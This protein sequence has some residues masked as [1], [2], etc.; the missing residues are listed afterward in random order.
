MTSGF[1]T[2]SFGLPSAIF[3]PWSSTTIW[4]ATAMM[5]RITCSTMT[6]VR[7]RFESLPIERHRLVDLGRVKPGHH[8]V[9]QQEARLGRER[10]RHL[11]PPLV[12]RREIARRRVLLGGKSD[13]FDRL[14]R[15]R[16]RGVE[17]LVAQEGAGH[18][19]RQHRHRAERLRH[20]K[21]AR[22]AVRANI[23]RP[24][25]RRSRGRRPVIEPA[26]GR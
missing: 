6:M 1:A 2:I 16:A 12:D 3:C 14:A 11:Q 4:R 5:A 10:A 19:V 26:S 23:V 18:D 13:E 15:L 17:L 22:E 20:L 7:P 25:A 24:Q 9:E 21:G 8:L